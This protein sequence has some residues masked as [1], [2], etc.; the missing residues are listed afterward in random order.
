MNPNDTQDAQTIIFNYSALMARVDRLEKM[1][2]LCMET[3]DTRTSVEVSKNQEERIT[4][5][6]KII[7]EFLEERK[8]DSEENKKYE[9]LAKE[10][11]DAELEKY[12]AYQAMKLNT[13]FTTAPANATASMQLLGAMHPYTNNSPHTHAV[14]FQVN[15]ISI[16]DTIKRLIGMNK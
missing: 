3:L 6:E 12:K 4:D 8:V 2:N 1:F 14:G 10:R 11:V 9:R 5:L 15:T 7:T 13:G 16:D